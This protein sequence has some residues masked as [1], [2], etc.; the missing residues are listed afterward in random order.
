MKISTNS[1][2]Y[3]LW[4]FTFTFCNLVPEQTTRR[5]FWLRTILLPIPVG[6][7]LILIVIYWVVATLI[8]NLFTILSGRGVFVT[9]SENVHV[10]EFGDVTI[11][12]TLISGPEIA[13]ILWTGLVIAGFWYVYPQAFSA[14]WWP[15]VQVVSSI[16]LV[17]GLILLIVAFADWRENNDEG[18]IMRQISEADIYKRPIPAEIVVF[19]EPDDDS[20]K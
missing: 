12:N 11:G 14:Y 4:Y 7:I 3:I 20:K 1:W 9:W 5:R 13:S 16:A 17:V 2:L 15:V 19:V 6:I 10:H 18:R 8:V